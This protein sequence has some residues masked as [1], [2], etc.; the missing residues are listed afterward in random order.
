MG[1]FPWPTQQ[2]ITSRKSKLKAI[3]ARLFAAAAEK[4]TTDVEVILKGDSALKLDVIKSL[5]HDDQGG[6]ID[7]W[8][9]KFQE[10]LAKRQLDKEKEE[11]EAKK[12]EEAI[13][14]RRDEERRKREDEERRA[15]LDRNEG[16]GAH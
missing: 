11:A 7:S 10:E 8:S 13:Q 16:R 9:N 4:G 6:D 2:D 1:S 15:E 12:K 14:R 5:T 3:V